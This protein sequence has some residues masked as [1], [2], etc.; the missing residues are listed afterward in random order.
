MNNKHSEDRQRLQRAI[1]SAEY[2]ELTTEKQKL[3]CLLFTF[4]IKP[5]VVIKEMGVSKDKVYYL[6]KKN[7]KVNP[8]A[9]RPRILND[10]EVE[11]VKAELTS[12]AQMLKPATRRELVDIV[13]QQN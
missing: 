12:R 8:I 10:I 6:M 1:A 2:R 11:A 7:G 9:G 13:C 5:S 3:C 4:S